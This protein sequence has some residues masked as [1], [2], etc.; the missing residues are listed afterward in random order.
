MS[1]K[2]SKRDDRPIKTTSN[3]LRS[4]Y[5]ENVKCAAKFRAAACA[6]LALM[7][8]VPLSAEL[9]TRRTPVGDLNGGH[10]ALTLLQTSRPMSVVVSGESTRSGKFSGAQKWFAAFDRPAG[11]F[12]LN[13]DSFDVSHSDA[14]PATTALRLQSGRSPPVAATIYI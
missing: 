13:R 7:L 14:R 2:F 10:E 5:Y 6:F 9:L 12:L 3:H 11:D 8:A 4:W 1:V